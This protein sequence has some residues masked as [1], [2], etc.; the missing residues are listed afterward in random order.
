MKSD[1]KMQDLAP[2]LLKE[3]GSVHLKER[4]GTLM[5][6][7]E[8]VNELQEYHSS[9]KINKSQNKGNFFFFF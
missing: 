5:G 4:T 3:Y 8:E 1:R 7:Q 6:V 2:W 9:R